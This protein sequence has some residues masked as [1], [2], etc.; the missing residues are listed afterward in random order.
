M[1][2]IDIPHVGEALVFWNIESC[3]Y[4]LSFR[5]VE[6]APKLHI[7][8]SL[9]LTFDNESKT[10]KVEDLLHCP[11]NLKEHV[12][13][14]SILFLS[15]RDAAFHNQF[16]REALEDERLALKKKKERLAL[17]LQIAEET[18]EEFGTIVEQQ[19]KDIGG[20]I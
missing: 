7:L 12:V 9:W 11:S 5:E 18:Y 6:G 14:N 15:T 3:S 17:E 1:Q 13:V 10:W 16:I 4:S 20:A 8:I 19:I 2:M